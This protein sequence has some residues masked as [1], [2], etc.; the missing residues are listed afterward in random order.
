[1]SASR[2]MATATASLWWT[3]GRLVD[4]DQLLYV[5]ATARKREGNLQGPVVGTVMSNL[6]LE[7]ALKAQEIDFRRAKVG[8]R[9]VLEALRETGG[10]IGGETSG[11]MIVLDKTTTGT[12]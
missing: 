3:K 12:A 9:Y 1:M 4:G 2:S 6:G 7:H 8:D 5:L 10:I 11:H